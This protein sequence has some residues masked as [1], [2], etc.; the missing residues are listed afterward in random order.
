MKT[1]IALFAC[2]LVTIGYACSGQP[3]DGEVTNGVYHSKYF[4]FT[5]PL[6]KDATIAT[7]FQNTNLVKTGEE[8]LTTNKPELKSE[9]HAAALRTAVLLTASKFPLNSGEEGNWGINISAEY[10]GDKP[11]IQSSADYMRLTESTLKASGRPYTF[12]PTP[13][14]VLLGGVQFSEM[15]VKDD[16]SP[17]P[18]YFRMLFTI[19]KEYCLGIGI[20]GDDMSY[21][22]ELDDSLA[23]MRFQ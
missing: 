19:R 23:R 22:R 9:Y 5:L 16:S 2:C 3:S 14:P 15:I 13:N 20:T 4:D 17:S 12:T 11:Q 21:I 18:T 7:S 8:T 10:V 6:P 1:T